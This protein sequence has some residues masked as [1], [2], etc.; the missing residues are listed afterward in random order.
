MKKNKIN[1]EHLARLKKDIER[2]ISRVLD[3]PTDYIYLSE[4]LQNEG[5]G[6]ISPTTLKRVWGYIS[7]KGEQYT[8]SSYTLKS[9]CNLIGF[10]DISE[11]CSRPANI[12]SR[13]YKG[14][15]I[16]TLSLPVDTKITILWQPNRKVLLRYVGDESFMVIENENSRLRIG[17]K[18][19]CSSLTRYAPA[20]FRV[21]RGGNKPFSYIA[22]SD[23]GIFYHLH[24]MKMLPDS[25]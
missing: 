5:H 16:E 4:K 22:G 8:P 17:D 7:D 15:Y 1:Q 24:S 25:D 2:H 10:N 9:L 21:H 6:Y 14:E 12:Q 18:V 20:F 11:Y 3:S 19:Q 13:E 23:Q